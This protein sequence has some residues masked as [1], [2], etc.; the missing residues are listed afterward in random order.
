MSFKVYDLDGNDVTDNRQWLID[1]LGCLY[2]FADGSL[3]NAEDDYWY[4]LE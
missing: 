4:A 3:H 1:P 2:I